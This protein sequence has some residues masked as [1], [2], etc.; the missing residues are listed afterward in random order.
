MEGTFSSGTGRV[1]VHPKKEKKIKAPTLGLAVK[2][3]VGKIINIYW[4]LFLMQV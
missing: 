4:I 2:G 3:I 1:I